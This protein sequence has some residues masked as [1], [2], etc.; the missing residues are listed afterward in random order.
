[1]QL[2]VDEEEVVDVVVLKAL[3]GDEVEVVLKALVE[4]VD[5]SL[6]IEAITQPL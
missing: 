1:M 6:E 2:L 5:R 3:F 4:E